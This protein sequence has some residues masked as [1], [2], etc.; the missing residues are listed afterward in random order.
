MITFAEIVDRVDDLSSEEIDELR[1]ILRQK[2]QQELMKLVEDARKESA[3]GKTI[4]FSS[5]AELTS[6]F[7]KL[8]D[9]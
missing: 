9:D 2:K 1:E 5:T 8:K 6:Y 3:E 4:S 7:E